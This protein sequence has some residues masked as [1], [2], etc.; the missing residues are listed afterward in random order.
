MET[1][2]PAKK[3]TI[4]QEAAER[5]IKQVKARLNPE[6][7]DEGTDRQLA[8]MIAACAQ[9][10]ILGGTSAELFEAEEIPA[11]VIETVRIMIL[12]LSEE[13]PGLTILSPAA[14]YFALQTQ[15]GVGGNG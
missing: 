2:N 11:H 10:L 12:D 9:S 5:L 8:G 13:T 1:T 4:S 3:T 15:L 14:N 6:Y 7:G